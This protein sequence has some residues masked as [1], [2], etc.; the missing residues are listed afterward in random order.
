[1]CNSGV[2]SIGDIFRDFNGAYLF[3]FVKKIGVADTLQAKLWTISIGLDLALRLAHTHLL[4]QCDNYDV[5]TLLSHPTLPSP[6]SLVR[7]ILQVLSPSF[8]VQFV[9]IYRKSNMT[10]DFVAK[11]DAPTDGSLLSFST[12]PSGLSVILSRDILAPL[13]LRMRDT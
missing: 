12:P 1:M 7:S 4:V 8:V 2:D 6:H 9:H 11:I 10:A 5:V 3:G 13:H